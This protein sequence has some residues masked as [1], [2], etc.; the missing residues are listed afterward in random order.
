MPVIG[1]PAFNAVAVLDIDAISFIGP[2]IH[3]VAHAA[4]VNTNTGDSYGETTCTNWS[5]NTFEKLKELRAAMELDVAA[6]V[7]ETD[8]V[9]AL[10]GSPVAAS[11]GDGIGEHAGIATDTEQA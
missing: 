3:L 10:A 7:F 11:V 5:P 4:F 1:V 2:S 6:K 9:G 8:T